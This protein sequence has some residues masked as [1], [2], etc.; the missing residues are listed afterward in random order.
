MIFLLY[1]FFNLLFCDWMHLPHTQRFIQSHNCKATEIACIYFLQL[2]INKI[3]YV[4]RF[5]TVSVRN[6]HYLLDIHRKN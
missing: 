6:T 1:N 3:N 4:D 2:L 5:G